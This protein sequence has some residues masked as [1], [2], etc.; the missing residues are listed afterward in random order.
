M[1]SASKPT[2]FRT[3][4]DSG[5]TWFPMPSP[6]MVITVY[7][8]IMLLGISTAETPRE[9][10]LKQDC[11]PEQSERPLHFS[12][13]PASR[14]CTNLSSAQPP[15][16]QV[17]HSAG[18]HQ[19]LR[20]AAQR[21]ERKFLSAPADRTR[22]E[23]DINVIPRNDRLLLSRDFPGK[24]LAHTCHK[25]RHLDAQKAVVERIAQIRLREAGRDYQR[26][27][28]RLQTRDRLFAA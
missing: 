23:I 28:F 15:C 25:F 2:A 12:A 4:N 16:H 13:L 6:G 20:H 10:Q 11:H 9:P 7:F 14:R 3:R 27:A 22:S 5:R 8:A 24:L 17:L 1:Y 18:N 19:R 26:N 21:R